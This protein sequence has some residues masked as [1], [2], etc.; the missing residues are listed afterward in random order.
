MKGQGTHSRSSF[1]FFPW[2]PPGVFYFPE[3]CLT[4]FNMEQKT[5]KVKVSADD[6]IKGKFAAT[7]AAINGV[8]KEA[9]G[10]VE[11]GQSYSA[12]AVASRIERIKETFERDLAELGRSISLE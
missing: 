5:I 8:F 4:L 1:L 3:L 10:D 12:K 7:I 2:L 6:V 9:K 11:V